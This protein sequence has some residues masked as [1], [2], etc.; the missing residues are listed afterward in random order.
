MIRR[1]DGLSTP[2]RWYIILPKR[3]VFMEVKGSS[4]I[5]TAFFVKQR[6]GDRFTV[7]KI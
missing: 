1:I 7:W 6:F 3:R 4:V 2:Q 5:P